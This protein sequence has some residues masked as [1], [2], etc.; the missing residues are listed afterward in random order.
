MSD[1]SGSGEAFGAPSAVEFENLVAGVANHEAKLAVL[2]VYAVYADHH[3]TYGEMK[4]EVDR[5]LGEEGGWRPSKGLI[6]DYTEASLS[7]IGCVVEGEKAFRGRTVAAY[8]VTE[9]GRTHGLALVGA[10]GRCSIEHEAPSVQQLLSQTNSS[11]GT[12]GPVNRAGIIDRLL[13]AGDE[14]VSIDKI[15]LDNLDGDTITHILQGLRPFLSYRSKYEGDYNRTFAIREDTAYSGRIPYEDISAETRAIYETLKSIREAG[16]VQTTVNDFIGVLQ[17]VHPNVNLR[18]IRHNLLSSA[19]PERGRLP[20]I[21][22]IDEVPADKIPDSERTAISVRPEYRAFCKDLIEAL[23]DIKNGENTAAHQ[24]EARDILG[25]P[26][27]LAILFNKAAENSP[28]VQKEM[29]GTTIG[30]EVLSVIGKID[31][32]NPLTSKAIL[33]ELEACGIT[34]KLQTVQIALTR[35]EREGS[36]LVT[37]KSL[38]PGAK[39]TVKHYG[40]VPKE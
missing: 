15:E 25:D 10:V 35:L 21:Q 37:T 7:D 5:R 11:G 34:A 27:I 2:G 16:E 3:M 6:A 18:I 20:V 32:E 22:F 30:G 24:K 40:P 14:G 28:R 1:T 23:E 4:T 8:Q 29:R 13:A 31:P 36:T 12:R 19:T 39:R 38:R 26:E 33:H 17:E 9:L